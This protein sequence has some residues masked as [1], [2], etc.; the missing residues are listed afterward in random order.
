MI[1]VILIG[2]VLSGYIGAFLSGFAVGPSEAPSIIHIVFGPFLYVFSAISLLMD[3]SKNMGKKLKKHRKGWMLYLLPSHWEKLG[4]Y[5]WL[6]R[7]MEKE[8]G[9][10]N[11]NR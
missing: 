6:K 5:Q 3:F 7:Q 4:H 1:W 10:E 2:W 9:P 8:N 11:K